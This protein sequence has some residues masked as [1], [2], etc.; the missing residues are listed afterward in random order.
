MLYRATPD[1]LVCITQPTHAWVSGKLAR[2]WGNVAFGSFEPWQ[3]VCLGAE[4]HDIGWLLWEATPTLNQKTGCPHSFMELATEVHVGIWSGAKHLAM[5]LGRYATLLV[6]LHGT[7]LYER[8]TSWQNSP[9]SSRIVQD[10]LTSE[11]IFQ[12]Q[13]TA[14]LQS[15][16]HY[17]AYVSPEAIAYNRQ[18][19]ATWDLLSLALCMGL[20]DQRQVG[21]VPITG[22]ETTL[23]LIPIEDDPTQVKVEPWPFQPRVVTLVYEGRILRETF[24]DEEMMRATLMSAPWVTITT[25]LIP[26][27]A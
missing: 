22:G 20:D 26:T 9:E 25:T 17:E 4:Q 19:V 5:P 3:E 1:G 8:Y 6:S 7:G 18:L 27:R 15:D 24:T 11:T 12:Q 10:F 13:L 2:A 23:T 16:P 21:Q 14:T